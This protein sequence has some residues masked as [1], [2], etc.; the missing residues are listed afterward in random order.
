MAAD[1]STHMLQQLDL[2]L[3]AQ[4]AAAE[5]AASLFESMVESVVGKLGKVRAARLSARATEAWRSWLQHRRLVRECDACAISMAAWSRKHAAVGALVVHKQACAARRWAT[6]IDFWRLRLLHAVFS[7]WGPLFQLY[8]AECVAVADL[9]MRRAAQRCRLRAAM[10]RWSALGAGG[11]CRAKGRCPLAAAAVLQH[12]Q[13]ARG[14]AAILSA[15][16]TAATWRAI[17]LRQPLAAITARARAAHMARAFAE[18]AA[19]IRWA[20]EAAVCAHLRRILAA[21]RVATCGRASRPARAVQLRCLRA[22]RARTRLRCKMAA[23]CARFRS[24]WSQVR[25]LMCASAYWCL[26]HAHAHTRTC[27]F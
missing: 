5:D 11:L 16:H 24:V 14:V 3:L 8:R 19:P 2:A 21:M 10:D 22:W 4:R 18:L 15:W 20:N 26:C 6:A 9:G 13:A 27:M 12:R 23:E 17:A 7:A 1:G 25:T